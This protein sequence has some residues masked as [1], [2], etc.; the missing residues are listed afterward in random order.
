MQRARNIVGCY[1]LPPFA[2]LL[3]GV[4]G[5]CCAIFE[6]SQTFNSQYCCELLA[7]NAASVCFGLKSSCSY[8]RGVKV[9]LRRQ[10]VIF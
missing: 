8:A 7:N 10:K 2:L 3:L 1:M 5:S 9:V 6:T 4:V